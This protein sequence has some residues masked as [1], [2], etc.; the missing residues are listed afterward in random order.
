MPAPLEIAI[1]LLLSLASVLLVVALDELVLKGYMSK[2]IR[3][4]LDVDE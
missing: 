2:K 4:Y 1:M 3:K